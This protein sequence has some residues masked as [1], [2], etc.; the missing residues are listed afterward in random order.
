M[1]PGTYFSANE[2]RLRRWQD[3][4]LSQPFPER[5]RW[6]ESVIVGELPKAAPATP[7]P[8]APPAAPHPWSLQ[9]LKLRRRA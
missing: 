9:P 5:A 8:P 7:F 2:E 1:S 4:R 6:A 3:I